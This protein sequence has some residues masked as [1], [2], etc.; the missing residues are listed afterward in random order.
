MLKKTF[1]MIKSACMNLRPFTMMI[2]MYK[3][4]RIFRFKSTGSYTDISDDLHDHNF[5][6]KFSSNIGYFLNNVTVFNSI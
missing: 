2:Y 6:V 4:C 5:Q 1:Q 3:K